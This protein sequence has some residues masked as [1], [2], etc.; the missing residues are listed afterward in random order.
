MAS[1]FR[2]I[3]RRRGLND[4]RCPY[5]YSQALGIVS[6]GWMLNMA[7]QSH[8][9]DEHASAYKNVVAQLMVALMH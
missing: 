3:K 2:A 4:G 9:L 1:V 7:F 8:T 6:C 5:M